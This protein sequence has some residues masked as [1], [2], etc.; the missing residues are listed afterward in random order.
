MP[1]RRPRRH[2][3]C[4]HQCDER[5][6]GRKKCLVESRPSGGTLH[7]EEGASLCVSVICVTPGG[8]WLPTG[9][10]PGARTYALWKP[11]WP[12][13]GSGSAPVLKR[14]AIGLRAGVDD[15]AEMLAK[16]P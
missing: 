13:D 11:P 16:V 12:L 6:A 2:G 7:V 10:G 15:P 9:A 14:V 8:L 4:T 3:N 1:A 5:N